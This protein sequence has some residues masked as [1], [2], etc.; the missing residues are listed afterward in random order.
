MQW[1]PVKTC[2]NCDVE[3]AVTCRRRKIPR[4]YPAARA[5]EGA[6]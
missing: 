5:V 2:A 3:R 1:K 6:W 4:I